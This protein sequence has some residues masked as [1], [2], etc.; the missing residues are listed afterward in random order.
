[1][2]FSGFAEPLYQLLDYMTPQLPT[3]R[4]TST[5]GAGTPCTTCSEARG[6]QRRCPYRSK[7][8]LSHSADDRVT[9]SVGTKMTLEDR[10]SNPQ[11][12]E[13]RNLRFVHAKTTIPVPKIMAEWKDGGRCF[14]LAEQAVGEPLET[15]WPNMSIPYKNRI[16][17]Q[18]G[19]YLSQL[20]ELQASR[21]QSVDGKPLYLS[22]LFSDETAWPHGPISTIEELS[23][24]LAKEL[25]GASWEAVSVVLDAMPPSAPYTLTHGNLT[26][27]NI[28]VRNGNLTGIIGW[29]ESG[30][31]PVWWEHVQTRL[32][33]GLHDL[34]WKAMLRSYM[35]DFPRRCSSAI[36]SSSFRRWLK[37]TVGE[38]AART[39]VS[40]LMIR[41][42]TCLRVC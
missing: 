19:H 26:T 13:V 23:T 8:E 9:W 11:C 27:A 40:G 42:S 31:L 18:A 37:T 3:A 21:I 33:V 29:E 28:L 16:T 2:A 39:R 32:T 24:G 5:G 20:R 4:S 35:P 10:P 30:Y 7:V 38:P 34:E 17:E 6:R 41:L 12:F 15:A 14:V 22:R 1:M 25:Q 36:A